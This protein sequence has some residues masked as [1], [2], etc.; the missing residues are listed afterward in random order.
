M[1]LV[2]DYNHEKVVFEPPPPLAAARFY[3]AFLTWRS[4]AGMSN[5]IADC[6]DAWLWEAGLD[7]VAVTPQH[8]VTRRG[9]EDFPEQILLWARSISNTIFCVSRASFRN[10]T[11]HCRA[12]SRATWSPEGPSSA[13]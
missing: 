5:M 11:N 10:R 9:D 2:L 13:G 3:D 6:L 8:E 4:D 12:W 1:V 7:S